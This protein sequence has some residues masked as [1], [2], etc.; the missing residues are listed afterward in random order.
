EKCVGIP[1]APLITAAA[2]A[3]PR[4]DPLGALSRVALRDD[5]PA[6]ALR[7]IAT[8]QLGDLVR[9]ESAL[10]KAA[11]VR[12]KRGGHACAV[13]CSR[14]RT[15]ARIARSKLACEGLRGSAATLEVHGDS[16]PDFED[17]WRRHRLTSADGANLISIDLIF[18]VLWGSDICDKISNLDRIV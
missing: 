1:L 14:G 3:L 16:I 4:S 15:R 13:H 8:A 9:A 6:L 7:G 12:S 11:R 5:A 17:Q 10:K 2:C 18:I